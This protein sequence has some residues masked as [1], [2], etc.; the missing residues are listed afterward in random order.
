M[1]ANLKI[2]QEH[3]P[4]L[5]SLGTASAEF[6]ITPD[7]ITTIGSAPA[8]NFIIADSSV[9]RRHATISLLGNRVQL[10]D[11]GATNG[12][13]LNGNRISAPVDLNDGDEV[14]FGAVPFTFVNPAKDSAPANAKNATPAN[15]PPRSSLSRVTLLVVVAIVFAAGFAI[16]QY[17]I[18]F[19]RLQQALESSSASTTA[20]DHLASSPASSPSLRQAAT[21]VANINAP[22]HSSSALATPAA[23]SSND[24]PEPNPGADDIWLKPLNQYRE[25]AGLTPVTANPRFSRADYLHSR[26]IVKNFGKQIAAHMNLGPAM[27][28][29][30]PSKPWYTAEGAAA[31]RAGDVDEAW[32]P[33]G[34]LAP[35]WALDN[36]MQ[37]PFHR[38]PILNPHLHSVG[39]GYMCERGVCIASLNVNGDADPI[40]SPP[41]PL[42]APIEYPPN[43][44]S[45]DLNSF[46][47]EWPDPLTSCPGYTLPTGYPISIQLGTLV[48]PGFGK[49]SLKRTSPSPANLEVCVFDGNTYSNPDAGTQAMMRNQLINFGSI[50]M[51]PRAPL[52]PGSYSVSITAGGHEYSW[53]FSVAH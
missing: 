15:L 20:I 48:N 43:R 8:N 24:V 18:N 32:N 45:I 50:V 9:S 31:G 49:Y 19:D 14:R 17:M 7:E 42:A 2:A 33:H 12:T 46:D 53:S 52:D 4:R 41:A 34:T 21:P 28:F 3:G 13:Y 51:M 26:Y 5:V 39:Y 35:T 37:S 10:T 27:H 6:A 22:S 36:W 38:F 23:V 11:L 44:A 30:D 47:G 40:M 1:N 16:T 25:S 29:E